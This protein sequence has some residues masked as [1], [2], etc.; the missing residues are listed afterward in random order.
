[1]AIPLSKSAPAQMTAR[2]F[3]LLCELLQADGINVEAVL[4]VA[5][6]ASA[7]FYQ[8]GSNI[9]LQQCEALI[10]EAER[11]SGRRDLAFALGRCIK[12]SNHEILGYGILTS[13][14]LDYAITVAARFYRLITPWFR[15]KYS[16]GPRQSDMHFQ[17][18][19]PMPPRVLNFLLEIV[20][21]S[22]HEQLKSLTQGRMPQYD[23][24]VS[25]PEPPYVRSYR[26][27][28]PA[29]FHFAAERLPGAH[30]VLDAE[31]VAQPLPMAAPSAL[32]L[33]E[34][35]CDELMQK[36]ALASGVSEWV[37]MML[38]ESHDG[39]PSLAELSKLLNLSPRTLDRHLEREGNRFLDLSKRIRH[40]RACELLQT[41]MSVT[42]VAYQVG[43]RDPA[44]FA[45]AFR[46]ECGKSP[47]DYVTQMAQGD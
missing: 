25:Y 12:L 32:K 9:T 3:V 26:E 10:D 8:A 40:E 11:A 42:Q 21:V 34:D 18:V 6:I 44:N 27:L 14:T 1:M 16:R 33:A 46:R 30:I 37:C 22:A 29:Q 2:Y 39:L 20:V 23:V 38:R 17:P 7:Q 36:T 28:H 24:F 47:R 45:R 15:L 35:R 4:R 19:M 13:P 5:R 43:Y 41:G 31:M